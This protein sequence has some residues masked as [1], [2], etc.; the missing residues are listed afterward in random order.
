M[1]AR[2]ISSLRPVESSLT[3]TGSAACLKRKATILEV[4]KGM[5]AKFR[6]C[7][8]VAHNDTP[9]YMAASRIVEAGSISPAFQP[10][11]RGCF[12]LGRGG[13]GARRTTSM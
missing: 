12:A 11:Y 4:F 9:L 5:G 7:V 3:N 13:G 10:Q 2:G 8:K 1:V 6:G